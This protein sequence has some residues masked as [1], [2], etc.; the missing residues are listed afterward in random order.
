M[1]T[2]YM[3]LTVR[4]ITTRETG[5]IATIAGRKGHI[6]TEETTGVEEIIVGEETVVV[7]EMVVTE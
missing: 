5:T 4:T 7:E 3:Y 1:P 6:V 2:G